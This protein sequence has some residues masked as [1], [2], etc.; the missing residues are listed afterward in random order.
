[1][2]GGLHPKAY[3]E[4]PSHRSATER[5][6]GWK[7]VSDHNRTGLSVLSRLLTEFGSDVVRADSNLCLLCRSVVFG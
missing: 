1:M 2:S 6:E 4:S 3:W 5:Q 7:M